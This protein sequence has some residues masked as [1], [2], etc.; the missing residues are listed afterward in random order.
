MTRRSPAAVLMLIS[1]LVF[2]ALFSFSAAAGSKDSTLKIKA[3][4]KTVDEFKALRDDLA[5]TPEGGVAVM[6]V[7]MTVYSDDAKLGTQFLTLALDSD[8]LSDGKEGVSGKQPSPGLLRDFK[9]RNGAKPWVAKSAFQGTSPAT[10]Y[11]LPTGGLTIKFKE[12]DGDV[13]DT[14]AKIFVYTSGADAPKP[15]QIKKN[16]KGLWKATE[17]SSFQGNCRPPETKKSDDL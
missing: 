13:K 15:M 3:L 2:S 17:W 14:T 12:Q 1:S 10:G 11:V 16:D 6:I 8:K 4:P 9:D 5:K 7:A